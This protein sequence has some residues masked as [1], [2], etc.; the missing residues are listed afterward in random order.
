MR[1]NTYVL[2][3]RP[4]PYIEGVTPQQSE[5]MAMLL[6]DCDGQE[7]FYLSQIAKLEA[8]EKILSLH[9][10]IV[11]VVLGRAG[12]IRIE[13]MGCEDD[14]EDEVQPQQLELTFAEV[15]ELIRLWVT[16]KE[17]FY[18]QREAQQSPVQRFLAEVNGP[19]PSSSDRHGVYSAN[20][21]I[22]GVAKSTR[23]TFF[24]RTW[25]E[26]QVEQAIE[27][28]YQTRKPAR[29]APRVFE[30][31]SSTGLIIEFFMTNKG[32]IS[33]VYPVITK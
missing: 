12:H 32:E 10:S 28:A 3:E 24:P 16:A 11:R 4:L 29:Q 2:F 7:E 15:R 5:L 26:A 21:M 6:H 19:K 13:D 23:N 27:E 22:L 8:G 14:S 20:V 25:T 31:I 9:N 18:Q 17:Q 1:I 33:D 30:G